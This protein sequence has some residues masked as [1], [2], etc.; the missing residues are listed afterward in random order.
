MLLTKGLSHAARNY[1]NKTAIIDGHHVFT[2]KELSIRTAKLKGSLFD[3][4]V[5]KGDRVAILMLNGFRYLEIMYGAMAAGAVCVP[6]NSRLSLGETITI[7]N[8]AEAKVL[9]IHEEF[10]PMVPELQQK[11]STIKHIILAEDGEKPR[12]EHV[13]SYENLLST[14][15][16]VD[17]STIDLHEEDIAGLFYT[18]GTTGRS[19]GVMLTHKNMVSNAYHVWVNFHYTEHDLYLHASP[20]FH[21]ADLASTFSITM[22]G[23]THTF[24]RS[25][26]PKGVLECIKQTKA[27]CTVLVPTMI[28]LLLNDKDFEQ[29]DTTSL[30]K[31][32]Y[33]ASPISEAILEQCAD[34]MPHV[35]LYQGYG[36]T[37][38]APILTVLKPKDHEGKRLKACGKAVE[39]VEIKVIDVDGN[40]VPVGE[41]GEFIARGPNI[42]KGYWNL[43]EE[44]SQAIR[45]GWYYTGDM[46]YKDEAEYYYLVDRAKDMIIS[47][48]ENVY[49]VEVENVLYKHPAV[50]ECAVIGIPNDKWGEVVKGVIVLKPQ[51]EVSEEEL[52][53]FARQHLANFKV[54]KSI[55][56]ISQLPKSGAGKILKRDLRDLYW[57]G[58]LRGIN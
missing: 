4:Q 28:T 16:E 38:A 13:H 26:T 31:F 48:G 24:V 6:L 32:I 54:P 34:R 56:F 25:F 29:Y 47:G 8:D 7:L 45:N 21:L 14:Q 50:L 49:S 2:Y 3:L 22:A 33:G 51:N 46:G 35:E 37:E 57:Q 58:E 18:G 1:S 39:G 41:I 15:S 5:K 11:V 17:F 12:M 55:A 40:E 19:K 27:T 30:K 43:V 42:M 53:L 9:Y 36:M 20:M 23:G 10:L 44:T 52:I